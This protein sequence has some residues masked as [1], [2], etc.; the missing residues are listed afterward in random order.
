MPAS[1]LRERRR[2]EGSARPPHGAQAIIFC[3]TRNAVQ[4]LER[5]MTKEGHKVS[6]LHGGDMPSAERDKIIDRHAAGRR[7]DARQP[8]PHGACPPPASA[9][10]RRRSSSRRTCLREARA[11]AALCDARLPARRGSRALRAGID[12]LQ[13]N[14]VVNYD[15]P[16][17]ANGRPDPETYLHRV[18]RTGRFGRTV[19]LASVRV[20]LRG[21]DLLLTGPAP[22]RE[23][24]STLCTT[25]PAG[26]TWRRSRSTWAS[27]WCPYRPSRSRWRR[28]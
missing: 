11:A 6:I 26:E 23:W 1:R 9:R 24:P 16:L 18:G 15:V 5:H 4:F 28:S 27:A 12:V 3:R 14:L 25:P 20:K 17:D 19:R 2:R 7:G 13:V 22:R 8:L 21:R 10:G